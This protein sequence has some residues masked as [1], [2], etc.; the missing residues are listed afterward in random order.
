MRATLS[1][2]GEA[3]ALMRYRPAFMRGMAALIRY[4]FALMRESLAH[5]RYVPALVRVASALMGGMAALKSWKS[6]QLDSGQA[7]SRHVFAF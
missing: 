6:Q 1:L 5:I 4:A 2:M 7:G 3:T